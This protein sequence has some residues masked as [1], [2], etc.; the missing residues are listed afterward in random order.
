MSQAVDVTATPRERE[1]AISA[2]YLRLTGTTQQDAAS[3]VGIDRRTLGRWESCSWWRDI[4][5]EASDRWLAGLAARARRGL[6][7]AVERDG[8]LA[9]RVLERLDP[10]LAPQPTRLRVGPDTDYEKLTDYELEHI[11]RGHGSA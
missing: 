3:A 6:E 11:A 5:R 4:Q 2:A 10:A 7:A 9:L 8:S 1:T